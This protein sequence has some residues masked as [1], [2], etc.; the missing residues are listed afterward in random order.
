LETQLGFPRDEIRGLV[1]QGIQASWLPEDKKQQLIREF[2]ED[3][4]WYPAGR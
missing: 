4:A 2:C 1:L 3:A